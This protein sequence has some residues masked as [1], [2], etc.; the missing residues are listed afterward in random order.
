MLE[1]FCKARV[2]DDSLSMPADGLAPRLFAHSC[3]GQASDGDKPIAVNRVS[4]LSA[5]VS[6]RL[7]RQVGP[8]LQVLPRCLL[9][10]GAPPRLL[11]AG[12]CH[13]HECAGGWGLSCVFAP[14]VECGAV[15]TVPV[16]LT[17]CL[18]H[19]CRGRRAG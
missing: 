13:A 9:S 4:M 8:Y 15:P 18:R 3:I 6:L 19:P 7:T 14:F 16:R 5:D 2:S 11:L 1:E 17:P 12:Y 10:T